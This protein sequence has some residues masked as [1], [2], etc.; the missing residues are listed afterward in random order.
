MWSKFITV[1]SKLFIY[2]YKIDREGQAS[3]IG[4]TFKLKDMTFELTSSNEIEPV[5]RR[6]GGSYPSKRHANVWTLNR[7]SDRYIHRQRIT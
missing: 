6:H 1:D 4:S 3:A 7:V 2:L 5:K